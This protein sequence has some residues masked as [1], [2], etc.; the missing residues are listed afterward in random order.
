MTINWPS[1]EDIKAYRRDDIPTDNDVPTAEALA[2]AMQTMCD[3]CQ[4]QFT[5]APT[6]PAN[7]TAR[8]FVPDHC[9][10]T[11]Y[12]GDFI[13][14]TSVVENGSTL[15][16]GT[17][18]QFEPVS[19]INFA[20]LAVPYNTI[21]RL[22]R[23]WYTYGPRGTVV[24]TAA[25]G[26]ASLPVRVIESVKILT[27]DIL[28]NREVKLGLVAVTDVAGISARTNPFVRATIEKYS[29]PASIGLA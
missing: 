17:G 19:R 15:T 6:D 25:W 10:D 3:E 14:V 18:H 27:K 23:E 26:W 4:H 9:P 16:L 12:V 11:L 8:T 7:Y 1:T 5:I 13:A 29:S 20:G 2:A 24:V 22:N 21:R 28:E